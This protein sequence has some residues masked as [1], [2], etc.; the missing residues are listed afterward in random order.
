MSIV[1]VIV[2]I[3]LSVSGIGL[4]VAL[5]ALLVSGIATLL[6]AKWIAPIT[7]LISLFP[8][9]VWFDMF[10]KI[11]ERNDAAAS[12]WALM[13]LFCYGFPLAAII[14][15]NRRKLSKKPD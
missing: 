6:G 1:F 2:S 7:I 9:V 15:M 12:D 5:F 10:V 8:A 14:W 13:L 11:F 3:P 4:V